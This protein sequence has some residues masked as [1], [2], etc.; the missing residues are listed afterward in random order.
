MFKRSNT[1]A[2]TVLVLL[3]LIPLP[4]LASGDEAAIEEITDSANEVIRYTKVLWDCNVLIESVEPAPFQPQDSE[5]YFITSSADGPE[6]EQAFALLND[7]GRSK[8]LYFALP[9]D[10]ETESEYPAGTNF[11]TT[12][13]TDPDVEQ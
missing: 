5:L 10:P 4:A 11:G 9:R 6:C 7:I 8:G 1:K 13:E 2:T 12:I 3:A